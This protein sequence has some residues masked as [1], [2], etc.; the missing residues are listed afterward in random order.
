MNKK[1]EKPDLLRFMQ[2][3][4]YVIDFKAENLRHGKWP[5]T[6][7]FSG[8]GFLFGGYGNFFSHPDPRRIDFLATLKSPVFEPL[9]RIFKPLANIDVIMV[10]DFS[11]SMRF[12]LPMSKIWQIAK[13]ATLFGFTAYRF[14]DRFGFIGCDGGVKEDLFFPPVRSKTIGLEIGES[15]L[16]FSPTKSSADGLRE[17]VN[18]LPKK[19]SLIIFISDF[20]MET[21]L[22]IDIIMSMS[23]HEIIPVIMRHGEERAWEKIFGFVSFGDIESAERKLVFISKKFIERFRAKTKENE[24]KIVGIFRESGWHPIILEPDKIDPEKILFGGEN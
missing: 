7:K 4:E 6:G 22:I 13:L 8:S 21:G 10:A 5:A 19:K 12:G 16:D 23:P 2:E 9:V 1:E 24:K 20:Y 15:L 14:G 18:Y 3:V 17:A 11:L